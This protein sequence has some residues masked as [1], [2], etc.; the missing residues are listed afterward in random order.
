[1]EKT[2]K[3][4]EEGPIEHF[5]GDEKGVMWRRKSIRYQS[6]A[7]IRRYERRD[8][9]FL[10]SRKMRKSPRQWFVNLDQ[11]GEAGIYFA[12]ELNGTLEHQRMLD[13]PGGG[14]EFDKWRNE[15]TFDEVEKWLRKK[16]PLKDPDDETKL[17]R[18]NILSILE[19]K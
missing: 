16:R 10:W 9:F 1:M 6:G 5:W 11:Q 7:K 19:Q 15:I 17:Y 18:F 3:I 4:I 8:G 2:S 13:N 14:L 12:E